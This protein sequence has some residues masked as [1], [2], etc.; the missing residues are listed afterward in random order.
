ME[1]QRQNNQSKIT[2]GSLAALLLVMGTL[3]SCESTSQ[4]VTEHKDTA[5][6]AGVGGASGAV[7]GGL[8][9]GTKGA[10][11]GGLL[12]V[13]AGGAVGNYM[14]RQDKDRAAAAKATGYQASQGN[15]VRVDNVEASPNT[16]R[17]GDTVNLASTYTILTPNN[18]TMAVQETREVRHDGALVA[19]PTINTQRANGTFTSTMPITLPPNAQ[20]GTYDVTT[21]VAMGDRTSRSMTTFTVQ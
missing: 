18:Q 4:A 12:G 7:I 3:S 16:V 17:S 9:G 15:V 1:T 5:V 10:I 11:I 2:A 8:A 20:K 13:L 6:G 21:T 14:E 19:N